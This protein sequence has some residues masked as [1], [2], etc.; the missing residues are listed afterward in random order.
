MDVRHEVGCRI[1][2]GLPPID[3]RLLAAESF[4]VE[5]FDS[6]EPP[7]V[8]A[9]PVEAEV[10]HTARV[11]WLGPPRPGLEVGR[12]RGADFGDLHP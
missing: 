11:M 8:D 6:P 7:G 4:Q 10:A 12:V 1:D 2:Q 9:A 3:L 5:Y